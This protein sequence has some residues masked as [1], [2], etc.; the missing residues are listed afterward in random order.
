MNNAFWE[1]R[2][3]VKEYSGK[4]RPIEMEPGV[5]KVSWGGSWDLTGENLVKTHWESMCSGEDGAKLLEATV[6][7]FLK[8]DCP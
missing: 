5:E 7:L 6:D 3:T 2:L 8:C 1:F 4:R